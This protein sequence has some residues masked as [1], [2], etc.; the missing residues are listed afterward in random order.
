MGANRRLIKWLALTAAT[1]VLMAMAEPAFALRTLEHEWYLARELEPLIQSQEL[2]AD[3]I[4]MEIVCAAG[5]S[6][7]RALTLVDKMA[8][9][10][11]GTS[12]LNTHAAPLERKVIVMEWARSQNLVCLD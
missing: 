12:Y 2:E 5:I 4:G 11:R 3:R 10:E 7:H 6:R 8:R 1:L 9:A